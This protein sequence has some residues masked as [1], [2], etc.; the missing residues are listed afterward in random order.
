MRHGR[1][2]HG[3]PDPESVE[4]SQMLGP[5]PGQVV[6]RDPIDECEDDDDFDDE[7]AIRPIPFRMGDVP[8][9]P[10]PP[11]AEPPDPGETE[12]TEPSEFQQWLKGFYAERFPDVL[13]NSPRCSPP[14][15]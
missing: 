10:P 9:T 4:R 7:P 12:T 2:V 1:E 8:T 13:A 11:T 5:L 15:E 6:K 3:A 14:D